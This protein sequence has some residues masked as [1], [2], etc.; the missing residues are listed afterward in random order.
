MVIPTPRFWIL[1]SLGVLI[2]LGGAVV[3][4]LESFVLPY[5]VLLFALFGITAYLAK[6]WEPLSVKRRTDPI[7]SANVSNTVRL[8]LENVGPDRLTFQI[9]DEAPDTA[10]VQNNEFAI[11][12]EP[13][14]VKEVAYQIK[15]LERGRQT[16]QGTFYRFAAPLGLCLIQKR[17]PN[18]APARVYPNVLAVREFDLLKQKGRLNMMGVRR[19]RFKGLGTEFES[20]R[21]YNEDDYRKID[22]K[23]SARRG[24]LVV[25]N[26]EQESNQNVI[27]CVDVGRH[28]LSEVNGIRKLDYCLD[29][30]LLLLHAAERANDLIG[31]LVFNDIVKRYVVPRKGKAQVAAVMDALYDNMA[32][33]VQP[34]Y[35]AA[36]AYLSR[37]WKRRSLV[38]VFTDAENYDQANELALALDSIRKRHLLFVVRVSDP[39][40]KELAHVGVTNEKTLFDRSA[41]L[42]YQNDRRRAQARLASVGIQSIEAEPQDLGAALVGA[43]LR[44]KELNLL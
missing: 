35:A 2:A 24:K 6:K 5:N 21:D 11:T 25:R 20:L 34:D 43:Y 19:S 4:G 15:P 26:F 41:A 17:F 36:F 9:R 28:M 29:A 31:L 12:L 10:L 13:Y 27:V 33:P 7:L 30:C 32:E 3:P 1:L 22:W 8:E 16:F 44:V 37:R 14:Q 18:E 38:V 23:A 42:W 39:H 40:L